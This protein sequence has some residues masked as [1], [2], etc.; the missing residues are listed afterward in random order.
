MSLHYILSPC[1]TSSLSNLV[2]NGDQ[3]RL[4][5]YHANAK[6][7]ADI[8][9]ESQIILQQ[10]IAEARERLN[11]ADITEARRAS[12][13]LNG[14]LGCYEGEIPRRNDIHLLLS[15]D[16]W[17]GEQ[18]ALLVQ[19]WLQRQG[20][21]LVVDV[22]RHSGL[23]TARLDEFQI[24]LSDLVKKFAEELP[25]YQQSGYRVIFNLTGG[26]KGVQGFLQSMANFYADETVYIFE[27]GDLLRIPRLPI[28][29]DATEII[30]QNLTL[31]RRLGNDLAVTRQEL[32]GL[33]PD[34]LL[35]EVE[36]ELALS[37]WG[38]LLWREAKNELYRAAIYPSP[39]SKVI[40]G[41]RWQPSVSKLPAER[42]KQVNE[43]ID[44]LVK[45]L[46]QESYNPASLDFKQLKG[47][48]MLPSTH[49]MDGWAD[50]DARRIYGHFEGGVFVLDRL[51]KAL[52]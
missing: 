21:D 16:T 11:Q 1:G 4:I 42:C 36:G 28:K 43:R 27:T 46:Y 32:D 5:F 6:N 50:G 30:E 8:P 44:Q 18:T 31:F 29:L 51:D 7:L 49:E 12:A 13:E 23:Q 3:K 47:K 39:D 17:I 33:I 14:I 41:E 45:H 25:A 15:T 37:A 20:S 35:F 9:P 38:E 40:Y 24:S 52:H 10:L 19:E 22:Y 2:K 48:S 26:F 34:T